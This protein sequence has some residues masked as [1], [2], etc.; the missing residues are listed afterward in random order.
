MAPAQQP[1]QAQS[2]HMAAMEASCAT[3]CDTLVTDVKVTTA[4][5]RARGDSP[6]SVMSIES[7]SQSE[8]CAGG[9]KAEE[10]GDGEGRE[11]GRAVCRGEE[12]LPEEAWLVRVNRWFLL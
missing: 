11:G 5:F 9:G 7:V 4:G 10:N 2:P 12:V 8:A 6:G 3:C 1:A